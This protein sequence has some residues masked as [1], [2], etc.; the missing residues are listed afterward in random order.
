MCL[1]SPLGPRKVRGS[2]WNE[3]SPPPAQETV[4][5]CKAWFP[6]PFTRCSPTF[7]NPRPP[8][9]QCLPTAPPAGKQSSLL[10]CWHQ[11]SGSPTLPSQWSSTPRGCHPS[12][13]GPS[14]QPP[15]RTAPPDTQ[16]SPG[17]SCGQPSW[18]GGAHRYFCATNASCVPRACV[19][20]CGCGLKEVENLKCFLLEF[21]K[22]SQFQGS[23]SLTLRSLP[24]P[25]HPPCNAA[26]LPFC[27]FP[28]LSLHTGHLRKQVTGHSPAHA[29][30][31]DPRQPSKHPCLACMLPSLHLII[32]S[33]EMFPLSVCWC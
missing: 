32:A 33:K 19:C 6:V 24:C 31:Q 7:L 28:Y 23:V 11:G 27:R 12:S 26:S 15:R 9:P 21:F 13:L 2:L 5:L 14:C 30:S 1:L 8:V 18:P 20:V 29:P 16:D 10:S 3:L 22:R 17:H 4:L 25:P